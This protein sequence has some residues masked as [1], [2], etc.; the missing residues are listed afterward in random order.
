MTPLVE[1]GQIRFVLTWPDF[2]ADLDIHNIFQVSPRSKC[3]VFFGKKECLGVNLDVDNLK[4]GKSGVETI[5][6]NNLG[7]YTYTVSVHRFYD[8]SGGVASGENPIKDSPSQISDTDIP[9]SPLSQSKATISVYASGYNGAVLTVN[10]PSSVN[11]GEK[12][13][14]YNWWNVL[15]LNGEKGLSSLS[16]INELSKSKPPITFCNNHYNK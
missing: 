2:P 8:V 12:S 10:I 7:K 13:S 9:D 3:E 1:E 11:E 16:I 4:G 6:I 5:T 14:D 15:C